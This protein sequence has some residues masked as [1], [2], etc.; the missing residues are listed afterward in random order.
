MN[1]FKI[2]VKFQHVLCYLNFESRREKKSSQIKITLKIENA[3][4]VK[5]TNKENANLLIIKESILEIKMMK[6][7]VK[8]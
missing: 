7:T 3:N 4:K 1:L 8:S 5:G 6:L 2:L